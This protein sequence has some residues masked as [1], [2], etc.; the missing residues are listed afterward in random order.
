MRNPSSVK[1]CTTYTIVKRKNSKSMLRLPL[2]D[3]KQGKA[4]MSTETDIFETCSLH[5]QDSQACWLSQWSQVCS[6][7]LQHCLYELRV[8]EPAIR[9]SNCPTNTLLRQPHNATIA[10]LFHAIRLAL[11]AKARHVES[12]I[13]AATNS[14]FNEHEPA[15]VYGR[16]TCRE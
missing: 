6:W 14:Y 4:C 7:S 3:G 15:K 1:C 9:A 13:L 5:K 10:F 11:K 8:G 2:A 12:L 16:N